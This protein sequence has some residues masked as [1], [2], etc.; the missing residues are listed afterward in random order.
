MGGKSHAIHSWENVATKIYI[1]SYSYIRMVRRHRGGKHFRRGKG[2]L[3]TEAERKE[4]RE[5]YG[6][7]GDAVWGATIN[8]V[9]LEQQAKKRHR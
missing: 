8:K 5:R 7:R 4:F 2:H 3:Y 6:K 9:K 1:S